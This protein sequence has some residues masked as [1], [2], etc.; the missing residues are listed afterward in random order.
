MRV[1][2]PPEKHQSVTEAV[3]SRSRDRTVARQADVARAIKG[4]MAA[5][6]KV[7]RVEIEPGKIVLV[8]EGAPTEP[9]NELDRFLQGRG[10]RDARST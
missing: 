5:G 3:R 1:Q 4:A 9:A 6:M 10:G 7:G 2:S 8:S